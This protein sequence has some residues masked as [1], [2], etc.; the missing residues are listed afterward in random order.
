MEVT[1]FANCKLHLCILSLNFSW[2]TC[3]LTNQQSYYCSE[4]LIVFAD[5]RICPG[6]IF[7]FYNNNKLY[8][9]LK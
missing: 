8:Y 9:D 3:V 5:A 7:R 4:R 1:A 6:E 2:M